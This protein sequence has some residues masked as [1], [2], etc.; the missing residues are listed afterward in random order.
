[1]S[2]ITKMK[3]S[4][5]DYS[6]CE[7]LPD[8]TRDECESFATDFL[9]FAYP[10]AL[11]ETGTVP[12]FQIAEQLFHL[13]IKYHQGIIDKHRKP[14]LIIASEDNNSQIINNDIITIDSSIENSESINFVLTSA[15]IQWISKKANATTSTST[16]ISDK[17]N[18]IALCVLMPKTAFIR[19]T[20]EL[21]NELPSITEAKLCLEL[22]KFFKVPIQTIGLRLLSLNFD[23]DSVHFFNSDYRKDFLDQLYLNEFSSTLV[24]LYNAFNL[25]STDL[26]LKL[27]F[28]KNTALYNEGNIYLCFNNKCEFLFNCDDPENLMQ[29]NFRS[30]PRLSDE[31]NDEVKPE[32]LSED[33][34]KYQE[35]INFLD[36][37]SFNIKCLR[38]LE[39]R[40]LIYQS[41]F[42]RETGIYNR[43]I[44]SK[45]KK[46]DYYPSLETV[47]AILV[48]LKLPNPCWMKLLALAGYHLTKKP[49][50]VIYSFILDSKLSI[51]EANALLEYKHFKPLGTKSNK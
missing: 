40:H 29:L 18:G 27:S 20:N 6:I 16:T 25:Y 31:P 9:A 45:L 48:G 11:E 17:A 50:H 4:K 35:S 3:H 2:K 14:F 21:K 37:E 41:N 15:L 51:D 1:M 10:R 8:W 33:L 36:N 5:F 12:I 43:D 28:Q 19:K 34:E 42:E 32:K 39:K 7:G 13:K 49:I 47:I 26:L 22:S 23:V 46:T 38:L 24:S 44:L 30:R